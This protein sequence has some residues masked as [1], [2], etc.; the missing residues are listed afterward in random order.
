MDKAQLKQKLSQ[1]YNPE[2]WKEILRFI[3]PNV[4]LFQIP[5]EIP[6]ANE[7]VKSFR[8]LG[9]V[10]LNDGKTLAIFDIQLKENI[11][12][13]RNRVELRNLTAKYIDQATTH[14]VLAVFA[15][16][17]EDYRFT[18]TAKETEFD[19]KMQMVTKQTEPK[20]YTYVLGPNES[21]RTPA[22]RFFKLHENKD[23]IA[24][25]NVVDAF[26]V[27]KL[28]KEFFNK[29]KEH[30][31]NF[32][33]FITG[34]RFKKVSGKWKEVE[35]HNP[36]A[37][38]ESVFENDNKQAR[39]FVKKLL[40]RMVF[41]QFLQK[42]A[43]MG[44]SADNSEWKNG[45][46]TFC[47]SLFESASQE[48]FHRNYLAPLFDALNTPNRDNDI[49]ELTQ[50]RIPYLN[51]GLFEAD[52]EAI[53]Q[54]D[55]PATH[56][57]NLFNFFG[58][59]NF[60]IDEN[61][62]NDHE[63]GIDPEMLG[64]IFENLLEDNKDK[65]A[66]YT[67]K[68][69]VQYMCQE[70]LI[71]YL[72]THLINSPLERGG[73]EADGVLNS[74][75]KG[76]SEADGVFQKYKELPYNPKLKERAKE[77]RKAG[78]LSEVLFWNQIKSKQFLSLD[79]HRQKI[80]GNYIVDF[81]C[82]ELNLVVEID[83]DSHN[84][85]FEYD[86]KRNEY[87]KSL[88]LKVIHFDDLDIKKNLDGVMDSL[89]EICIGFMNTPIVHEDTNK[90]TPSL[91]EA[92]LKEGNL[93]IENFIRTFDRGDENDSDNYIL[94]NAKQ[95]EELLDKVKIC[96]PAIG[97]GAFPMGLLQMIYRAKMTLDWTLDPA[98]VKRG[99]IQ[100]SIYGV[101]IEK[102]AV[103]IARLRFWLSLIVDEKAPHPLPNLDYKIMQGNSLIEE[104]HGI[105]LDIEKK[106][107]QTDIF[108]DISKLDNLIKE[109]HQKQD[110][111]FNAEHPRDKKKKR[112]AVETAIYNIFHS[113]L[114]KVTGLA[115]SEKKKIEDEL[116]EMTHGNKERNF[117][118]WK[119]Y[120]ADIFR[121]KGGFDVVIANPPYVNT[122]DVA[123]YEWRSNLESEFGWVDDLYNHF[124][125][126]A[127]NFTKTN[128]IV[129]FITSDTF[130]TIQ[131]KANMRK[132]LLENKI[133][134]LI[135]TPKAF[136]AMVDTAIFI[137]KKNNNSDI[138]Q[139]EF[140]D[141]R[142]PDFDQLG[143]SKQYIKSSGKDVAT[144]ERILDPLFSNLKSGK[145]YTKLIDINLFRGNLN[146]VFFSPIEMNLQIKEKIIPSVKGLHD[147][148]WDLIKTS[149][150]ISKNSV[151][152]NKYRKSLQSGD[153]TLLGMVTDGGVGLQTGNNGRFVGCLKGTKSANRILETRSKK[154]SEAFTKENMLYELYPTFS[155]CT[156]KNDFDSVLNR[157]TENEIRILFDEIKVKIDRDIFGQ[158]YLFRIIDPLEVADIDAM[159]ENEKLN[160]IDKDR[161]DHFVLYDKGDRDGNRWFAESPYYIDWSN[162]SV[163]WLKGNSGKKGKGMPVVRNPKFYFRAGFCWTNVLN[164]N[165]EY[166]KSRIKMQSVN[167]VGTMA[168]YPLMENI[169]AKYL[170]CI[171]NSYFIFELL[172]E[173][174]NA[175][176]NLQ[177][178]DMRKFPIIIPS[179]SQLT[180]FEDLFNR[181]YAIK[182]QQFSEEI[183]KETAIIKLNEIQDELDEMVY[184][185][186]GIER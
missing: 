127:V 98:E 154:L 41:L 167:D 101:D 53:R 81:Y 99:I 69:I 58:E 132:L 26:S 173:F 96:D 115:Q 90:N 33:Q 151:R 27:E 164:P 162:D 14:G 182:E 169:N 125:H 74:S 97:S 139:F 178:N 137:V 160:G 159:T 51:G 45:D 75:P 52:S 150:D 143:F 145:H 142:K 183:S 19:D 116:Q 108:G 6:V 134:H 170:V 166:I 94:Q 181:A 31:E 109:L 118:P 123:K 133:I 122:K 50:T 68:P 3:F 56:F 179:N 156:S 40:G 79:F 171:L 121:E 87:L 100:N 16:D 1:Q 130:F 60:T 140:S 176:V 95:I 73:R 61:D 85:K 20:R 13:A 149:R 54:M 25:E 141:I 77:L 29:Y 65:G 28:N 35:I 67:P 72:K 168:L 8:Q 48:Q 62:P 131:T 158:G 76:G 136:S 2:N 126:L 144:W 104:F 7:K 63:V 64:H 9:N 111:F 135:P 124:T 80:I 42:K 37:Y 78:V 120:F 39:D 70:S 89:R 129:T 119:L 55:F 148:Y 93:A 155:N 110:G 83:G 46:H 165:A 15:S 22:D 152:L 59:Y 177:I 180:K 30:Y 105:S 32:V 92:P 117:F 157:M 113:E 106:E 186:Y 102:G 114:S 91:R 147:E 49:F 5:Q 11:S 185:L 153:V 66:F 12:V 57:E 128:G 82:P 163:G 107:T 10:R 44:C 18:F 112:E 17:A 86:Q 34:K 161:K 4:A 47:K 84:D 36:S 184:N 21:C 88:E 175:S 146:Q 24:L 43:W 71:Q 103:D 38:L 138:Y 23:T 172:R 174:L